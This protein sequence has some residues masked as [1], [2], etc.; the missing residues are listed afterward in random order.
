MK[1]KKIYF[2]LV[3]SILFTSCKNT[4]STTEVEKQPMNIIVAIDF[5]NL[6]IEN[7][8]SIAYDTTIINY[9]LEY[10]TKLQKKKLFKSQDRLVIVPISFTK[11]ITN[12]VEID[13]A[14]LQNLTTGG[15]PG[16]QKRISIIKKDLININ[17]NYQS[18]KVSSE[19]YK[20]FKDELAHY[21][22]DEFFNKLIIISNGVSIIKDKESKTNYRTFIPKK[23]YLKVLN[24]KNWEI[25]G[26]AQNIELSP[27]YLK[28]FLNLDV[29]M[30]PIKN[31]DYNENALL[32]RIWES[33]FDKLGFNYSISSAISNQSSF[34]GIIEDFL[35][36]TTILNDII[37]V[38]NR[39]NEYVTYINSENKELL[40][41]LVGN[42]YLVDIRSAKT[43][44]LI[45]FKS[46]EYF[47]NS[48][49][50]EYDNPMLEFKDN[51]LDIIKNS[52]LSMRKFKIF[53]KGSADIKGNLT[54]IAELNPNYP[55][56]EIVY[57]KK[58][59]NSE[60]QYIKEQ[61]KTQISNNK[62]TNKEL[63]NLR[64]SF[65]KEIFQEKYQMK[66]FFGEVGILDGS[67]SQDTSF[68]GRNVK[69]YLYLTHLN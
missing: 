10:F 31:E 44:H 16:L 54:F 21:I 22:K 49:R 43:N 29:L 33:W 52:S 53:V 57:F 50:E 64:A 26:L 69:I 20:F 5:D 47:I 51:I 2:L 35:N 4:T 67:I 58:K 39:T 32:R 6:R 1:M 23:D 56:E 3:I 18:Q 36:Q 12:P 68:A 40:Q 28:R 9:V 48:F 14:N 24:D 30:L 60:Y 62:F 7:K 25:S 46:G 19:F 42:Y 41:G 59:N 66:D 63:P 17:K 15:Y 61:G 65:I 27:V 8:S 34:K 55:Y 37:T 11:S 38:K 13:M 45:T